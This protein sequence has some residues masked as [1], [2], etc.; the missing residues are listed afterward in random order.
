MVKSTDT[1]QI[2]AIFVSRYVPEIHDTIGYAK[3]RCGIPL[4]TEAGSVL[5]YMD[6]DTLRI[7]DSTDLNADANTNENTS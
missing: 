1:A 3:R 6:I 7:L 5:M 2:Y 4:L